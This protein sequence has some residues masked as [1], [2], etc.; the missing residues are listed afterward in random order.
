[1]SDVKLMTYDLIDRMNLAITNAR[2]IPL[3]GKVVVD[4]EEFEHIL[5]QLEE[6]IPNDLQQART[7]LKDIEK[8]IR[9][10]KVQAENLVNQ[11]N[12]Q[13]Q[14]TVN[15]ANQ[16]AQDTVNQ[17]NQQATLTVNQANQQASDMT[18]NA[19][20]QANAMV[21]DAQA[22]AQ[23]II[24]DAQAQAN[25]LVAESE[26]V[27]RATAQAQEMLDNA[28]RECDDYSMRVHAA[29]TQMVEQ[30]DMTLVQQLDSLRALH[31]EINMNR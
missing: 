5:R 10:S 25:N 30:A 7:F 15:Q 2:P 19:T 26:I 29:V 27:T 13:A 8:L 11:A 24:A 17:A 14:N 1:M 9:D 31:Q 6:N 21:A 3:T 18:R 28:H 22:R 20:E 12:E 16:Q 23:A 4:R